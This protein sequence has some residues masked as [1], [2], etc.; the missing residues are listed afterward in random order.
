MPERC[1]CLCCEPGWTSASSGWRLDNVDEPPHLDVSEHAAQSCAVLDGARVARTP[2][3]GTV[4]QLS[5]IGNI[6][7]DNRN[8][9]GSRPQ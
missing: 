5:E 7:S 2:G 6:E 4:W 1:V 8:G 3:V 9:R